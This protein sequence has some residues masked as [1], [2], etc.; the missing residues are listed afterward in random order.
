MGFFE[1][2]KS[3]FNKYKSDNTKR[4]TKYI[5]CYRTNTFHRPGCKCVKA[6]NREN[7]IFYDSSVSYQ[8]LIGLRMK[9]CSKCKPK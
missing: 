3:F 5:G 4:P 1:Q 7:L 6:M 2:I 8:T 9:P